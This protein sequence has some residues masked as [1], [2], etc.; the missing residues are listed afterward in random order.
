MGLDAGAN[1]YIT[2]P[3]RLAELLAR[4][5]AHCA[6]DRRRT[7]RAEPLRAGEWSSTS[8]PGALARDEELELRPKE[9]E[10]LALLVARGRP[11]GHAGAHHG[12]LGPD[13]FGSTKTLDM[14]ISR[15]AESSAA[16]RSRRCAVSGTASSPMRRRILARDRRRRRRRDRPVRDPAG[17][18]RAALLP[19]QG[20]AAL[21][22][23][24][25][26]RHARGRRRA[27]RGS[28]PIELPPSHD[29]L[30]VYDTAGRRVDGP[31]TGHRAGRG[32]HRTPTERSRC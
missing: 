17:D 32:R 18:R 3:F 11:R 1:D 22:A 14:H 7:D 27:P 19:R 20:A 31:R 30:A 13:W 2:K 12:G 28:D 25:R 26:R 16:T 29:A 15:C 4:V 5:R 8:T 10:L 23:R 6:R 9:F 21:A 24:H